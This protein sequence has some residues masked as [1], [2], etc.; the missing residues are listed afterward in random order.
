MSI[1][2]EMNWARF[3]EEEEEEYGWNTRILGLID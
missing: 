2:N 1:N 3:L